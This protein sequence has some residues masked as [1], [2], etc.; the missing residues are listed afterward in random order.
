MNKNSSH[1]ALLTPFLLSLS[2]IVFSM[3]SFC[4]NPEKWCEVLA[5]LSPCP[6]IL[7]LCMSYCPLLS[8]YLSQ[9]RADRWSN[10]L[11]FYGHCDFWGHHHH[12]LVSKA[13]TLSIQSISEREKNCRQWISA[14]LSIN[15]TETVNIYFDASRAKEGNWRLRQ[16]GVRKS[17]FTFIAGFKRGRGLV[18]TCPHYISNHHCYLWAQSMTSLS[19]ALMDEWE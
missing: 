9:A 13:L 10:A 7:R 3:I 12:H 11:K 6:H 2:P 14:W 16:E 4:S 18:I 5:S 19:Q 1:P 8:V 15:S 17:V